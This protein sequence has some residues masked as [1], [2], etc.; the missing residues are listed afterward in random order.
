MGYILLKAVFM[1]MCFLA[2]LCLSI[3]IFQQTVLFI[4]V[5]FLFAFLSGLLPMQAVS[6]LTILFPDKKPANAGLFNN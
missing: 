6:F 1:G 4:V 5:S 2:L 3:G